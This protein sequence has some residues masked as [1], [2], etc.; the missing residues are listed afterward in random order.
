MKE[1]ISDR[2]LQHEMYLYED[3]SLYPATLQ[4]IICK[5]PWATPFPKIFCN[6][7][8]WVKGY[9]EQILLPMAVNGI[10]SLYNH[11]DFLPF[12]LGLF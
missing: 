10:R 7:F 2:F 3:L 6:F 9:L 11:P 5:H 8:L 12:T 4:R 1:L